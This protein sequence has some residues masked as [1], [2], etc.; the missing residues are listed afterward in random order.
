[1]KIFD[2][3]SNRKNDNS[4]MTNHE[5]RISVRKA[6]AFAEEAEKLGKFYLFLKHYIDFLLSAEK[7]ILAKIQEI[8]DRTKRNLKEEQL[9]KELW[10]LRYAAL[11]IWFFDLNPPKNQNEVKENFTLIN[12][13]FQSVLENN[14][15]SD[16][17][18]WLDKGFADYAGVNEVN[19]DNLKKFKSHFT[20]KLAEK[21]PLIA[22]ECTEGRLGGELHDSIIELIMTTIQKDQKAFELSDDVSLTEEEVQNIKNTINEM[23]P[24]EK[25]FEDFIESLS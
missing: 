22:F 24:T 18:S 13:A 14:E 4:S 5:K 12:R 15:K 23:K 8:K 11:H 7:E 16:Y 17:L 1:M 21:V 3:F 9:V 25:D 10:I 2:W 20:E 19:F 6:L